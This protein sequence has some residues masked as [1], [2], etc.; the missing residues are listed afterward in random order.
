VLCPFDSAR[1]RQ[2]RLRPVRSL[3][4]QPDQ[5]PVHGTTCKNSTSIPILC[6]TAASAM[7]EHFK[8][9]IRQLL[10]RHCLPPVSLGDFLR[11]PFLKK[12]RND[13]NHRMRCQR[14][15]ACRIPNQISS[16]PNSCCSQDGTLGFVALAC[17]LIVWRKIAPLS[18][19]VLQPFRFR[20]EFR[21]PSLDW[22][23]RCSHEFHLPHTVV[24]NIR[25]EKTPPSRGD[26]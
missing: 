13:C 9:K 16:Q 11:M 6:V 23:Q 18:R 20:M 17:C 15:C 19:W 1:F 4:R 22:S 24:H 25:F 3:E 10:P 8:S 21:G 7:I 12:S 2:E 26:Q 14:Q 5:E